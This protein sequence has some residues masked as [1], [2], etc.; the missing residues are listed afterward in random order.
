[1][2]Q[3]PNKYFIGTIGF[4]TKKMCADYTKMIVKALDTRIIVNA[5]DRGVV[6]DKSHIHFAFIC[7][8]IQNHPDSGRKIGVGIKHFIVTKNYIN[9]SNT[10]AVMRCDDSKENFSW[11]SCC[12]FKE[13]TPLSKLSVTLRCA[14]I[15]DIKIFRNSSRLKCCICQTEDVTKL[16]HVDHFEPSFATLRDDF[17]KITTNP[18]PTS[19]NQCQNSYIS[20]FKEEDHD[21]GQEWVRYHNRH[22]NLQILCANCNLTK[23]REK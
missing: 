18:I 12:E 16:Y 11:G 19:Y 3:P 1:M 4:P 7:D 17:L 9:N 13:R 20:T 22:C 8:L 15:N 14:I 6:I 21:F 23:E 10:L 2:I 5:R